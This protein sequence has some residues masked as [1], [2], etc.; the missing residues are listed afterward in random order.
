MQ[1]I[2][3]LVLIFVSISCEKNCELKRIEE[4]VFDLSKLK[5]KYFLTSDS[6]E[7][8]SLI[9][10]NKID[11]YQNNSISTLMNYR[12]CEHF[13]AY[14]FEFK[15]ETVE[16][17]LRKTDKNKFELDAL[18]P[19]GE[20]SSGIDINPEELKQNKEYIFNRK[21]DCTLENSQI[22]TIILNG[23]KIKTIKTT[24]NKTWNTTI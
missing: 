19:C 7:T 15:N 20:I 11:V 16:I 10:I 2:I 3:I 24:D 22:Q 1:K 9:L 5:E 12:E 6:N 8:D 18:F 14:E 21:R 13:K 23:F 4:N 17:S